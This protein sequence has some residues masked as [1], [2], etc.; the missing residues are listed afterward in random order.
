MQKLQCK[1]KDVRSARRGFTLIELLVVIAIIAVLSAILF[2]VF[3]RARE[4]ARRA[5]CMSNLKQM[6]LAVMMYLQDYDETYPSIID[7]SPGIAAADYP[8]GQW[9]SGT[10]ANW[11]YWQQII[12]PYSKSVQIAYCPSGVAYAKPTLGQYGANENIFVDDNPPNTKPLKM[13]AMAAPASTYMIMDTG[14][15]RVY[16]TTTNDVVNPRG[17]NSYIPG[18]GNLLH[19]GCDASGTSNGVAIDTPACQDFLGGR[20]LGGINVAFA[21]GHVKWLTTGKVYSEAA[22]TGWGAWNPANS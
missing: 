12:Y 10:S 9:G 13:A 19:K 2:P 4:N 22:Q 20:H 3:A 18:V 5:S 6:G 17:Y 15:W 11:L 8:G 14:T 21:D 1:I 7:S 16:A